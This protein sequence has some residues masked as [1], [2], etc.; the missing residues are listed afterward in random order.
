MTAVRDKTRYTPPDRYTYLTVL[1]RTA[2]EPLL[3]DGVPFDNEAFTQA[4]EHAIHAVPM[5]DPPK[6]AFN[7]HAYTSMRLQEAIDI[8]NRH[9][10]QHRKVLQ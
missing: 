8:R 4:C 7:V 1:E 2:V 6:G 9:Y 3:A 10:L 5:N